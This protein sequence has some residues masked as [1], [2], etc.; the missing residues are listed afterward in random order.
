MHFDAIGRVPGDPILGLMEAYG[1]DTNPSKFDLGVGVYK[2]A[3][4]LTPI[5]ESVKQA[6]QR[7]VDRQTTKTYIGGHGDAAFG[8]LISELVLGA[9]S[10]H[11]AEKRAGATQTPGGT[12][13]LRLSADFIAQCLP[14]RGVWL[15][16]PTWPIHETIFA[17]AGVKASHYPY[18]GADNRLD[19]E[20]MLATLNQ[21]PKGDVVLLHACCHNPTGFDLTHDQWRQVLDVVRQREL[22]PLI[23]FA[24]Q[25]FGDGLEQDAWAVRLF[26]Q[27][28]PEVLITSSCSK[29]FGLY[30][31]RTGALIV[32]A[33]ES[34]KLLD[35]R[36]QL[37]NIARNLWSTPP[38]HGAAVVATILGDA[39]LKSL[40]ADEVQAMRL[41]IAQLR[42][43][44][45]DA[46]EPHGLRERFAHIGVQRGM[47]S[48]TG[49]T[50]EQVRHLRERHSVYMVG[51]GRAN[52]AGIDATRLDQFA[53]AI[54]DVCK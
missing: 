12:G 1:A 15:S 20:A 43:G 28:L 21:A 41:R 10:A 38:D 19:I 11:I 22:L 14:G 24:Y 3:Q 9:D 16:N 51:T 45:L 17:A 30:C 31:D 46:L 33:G 50:P 48:Y 44:L 42:S 32:C 27:A 23:D 35:I 29:N 52:V 2:D 4:G 8:Q 47:F 7:L 13:A 6:E 49:L 26:A 34:G 36:S 54:A 37:A 40:W 25:G 5:L 39:Q 18:V 53:E